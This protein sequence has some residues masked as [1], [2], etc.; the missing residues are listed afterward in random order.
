MTAQPPPSTSQPWEQRRVAPA[1]RVLTVVC[2]PDGDQ[3]K[4][5]QDLTDPAELWQDAPADTPDCPACAG[6]EEQETLL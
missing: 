1:R 3:T 6:T 2:H 4:C 5:G